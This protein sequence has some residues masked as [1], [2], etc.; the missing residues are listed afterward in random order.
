VV[1]RMDDNEIKNLVEASLFM[2]GRALTLEEIAR[3]CESGNLGKIRTILEELIGEY[4][5]RGV[6]II[7]TGNSYVMS[8]RKD[9]EEKVMNL[10]PYPEINTSMLKTLGFI[11][12]KQ[13]VKQAEVIKQRGYVYSHIKKLCEMGFVESRVDGRSKILK[14]TKKFDEYFKVEEKNKNGGVFFNIKQAQNRG[15]Q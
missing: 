6:N 4:S 2:A 3:I 12:Y 14:T 13:P 15:S 8:I 5:G 7:S 10:A 9:L 1:E 11:A